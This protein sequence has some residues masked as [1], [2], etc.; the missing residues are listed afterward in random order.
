L[1]GSYFQRNFPT[2]ALPIII[3]DYGPVNVCPGATLPLGICFLF[4][5]D[6]LKSTTKIVRVEWRRLL[7][8]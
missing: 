6:D 7:L 2:S 3:L 4:G 1:V 5:E 8:L